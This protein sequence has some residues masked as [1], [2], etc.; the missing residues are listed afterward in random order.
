MAPPK[1]HQVELRSEARSEVRVWVKVRVRVRV[2]IALTRW[3]CAVKRVARS[4]A[5]HGATP[6]GRYAATHPR[7]GR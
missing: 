5:K 6:N 4:A 3:S 7:R 1:P 2:R